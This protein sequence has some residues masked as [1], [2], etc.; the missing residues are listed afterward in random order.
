MKP[1][2]KAALI[3]ALVFPGLG[4]L[5]VLKR[6]ARG[7][8]FLLPCLLALGTL[9]RQATIT[10]E[11]VMNQVSSGALP[12]DPVLIAARVSADGGGAG[13]TLASLV[14]L[15][16]WLGSIADALWLGRNVPR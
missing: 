11:N 6:A 9:L 5:L 2:S 8:L 14:C 1:S 16:C 3:S 12:L 10:A 4:Q 7:C 13:S 15:L